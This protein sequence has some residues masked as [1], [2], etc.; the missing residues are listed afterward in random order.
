MDSISL[1]EGRIRAILNGSTSIKAY[2]GYFLS[3]SQNIEPKYNRCAT[4]RTDI[5]ASNYG[6]PSLMMEPIFG[7]IALTPRK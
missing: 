6:T 2:Y 1:A 5:G 3:G 7:R 4:N